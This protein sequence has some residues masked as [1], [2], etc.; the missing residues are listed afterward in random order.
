VTKPLLAFTASAS[1]LALAA[2]AAAQF[3][4]RPNGGEAAASPDPSQMDCGRMASMPN[5]PMS[6]ESCEAMKAQMTGLQTN[7]NS[8][9]GAKPGDEDMSCDQ[10]RAELAAQKDF[11]GVSAQHRAE[12][13]AAATEFQSKE[14][15]V[16]REATALQ[17]E[18]AATTAAASAAGM[19][20]GGA[21]AGMA[22]AAANQARNEAFGR[23]AQAELRPSEERMF[24]STTNEMGD[25]NSAMAANPRLGRLFQLAQQKNCH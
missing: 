6:A 24:N 14:R 9:A 12:G 5:A 10:I 20:P 3:H 8:G 18:E 21:A 23:H 15:Q 16:R 19:L 7:M 13:T 2:P 1:L 11:T 17:A 4:H 25:L 22:V